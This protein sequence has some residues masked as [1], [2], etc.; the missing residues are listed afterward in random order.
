MTNE[1]KLLSDEQDQI[2]TTFQI[3]SLQRDKQE[4]IADEMLTFSKNLICELRHLSLVRSQIIYP[5]QCSMRK[6][7]KSQTFHGLKFAKLE[8]C[9][10]FFSSNVLNH[11]IFLVLSLRRDPKE[12]ANVLFQYSCKSPEKLSKM[13][14]SLFLALFQQGWCIE[15]DNS[16]Y[17]TLKEMAILQFRNKGDF[18]YEQ[19][20][21]KRMLKFPRSDPS[22]V[23]KDYE[24]FISFV[25][26]YLFNSASLSYFQSSLSPIIIKLHSL[27]QLCDLKT[28]FQA[29][30]EGLA[31]FNYWEQLLDYAIKVCDALYKCLELLPP[32]VFKL[33]KSL[34]E[35]DVDLYLVYFEAF[36]NRALDNPAVLGLLPWHPSHQ[37]W[38]P[39]QDIAN[40]LR[41]KYIESL[42]NSNL[43]NLKKILILCPNYNDLNLEKIIDA[44]TSDKIKG[45]LIS[46][47][48]L[49][50]T[51][52][53]FPKEI[54]VTGSDLCL[55]QQA[56]IS[57]TGITND[58]IL[59]IIDKMS[60]V[61][62]KNEKAKDHFR[63]VI[64][65]QKEMTEAAKNLIVVSIFSKE[66]SENVE[67]SQN[68]AY[69]MQ[70]CDILVRFPSLLSISE[71]LNI[72]TIED[73]FKYLKILSPV[74]IEPKYLL[75]SE[76]VLYYALNNFKDKT[77]LINKI[78]IHAKNQHNWS[79]QSI[80]KTS[81]LRTQHQTIGS[82]LQIA[83]EIRKNVQTHLLLQIAEI[84]ISDELSDTFKKAM[85]KAHEFVED[86][87]VFKES[88]KNMI[89]AAVQKLCE[90]EVNENDIQSICRI[91]FFKLT[92]HITFRRFTLCKTYEN[93][94][95]H[96]VI[97]SKILEQHSKDIIENISKTQPDSFFSK[98]Q[99]LQRASD[100]LGHIRPN[101]G[102]SV[103]V[104]YILEMTKIITTL[105]SNCPELNFDICL[106][107][108]LLNTKAK[109]IF[110]LSK[111]LQH[112][113]SEGG[114]IDCIL[115]TEEITLLALFP[116]S[117]LMLLNECKNYDKRIQ[118]KWA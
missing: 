41:T 90:L 108:V 22:F 15:E 107:W 102:I 73:L 82:S 116:T 18:K 99:Y 45:T 25:S 31:L 1:I 72:N 86:I 60:E 71:A 47:T 117:I 97:I 79:L 114:Y 95:K 66:E 23:L 96:S 20:I 38:K 56:C 105:C 17:L 44:L 26:S 21:K 3:L 37:D 100:L 14:Y 115:S 10:D 19:P 48:E 113:V 64:T 35:L 75:Q 50:H 83:T 101:S 110:L 12:L 9:P 5:K 51:N 80:D 58:S 91:H 54:L 33:F 63:I 85:L 24:P 61:P 94:W 106:I 4:E 39:S 49:L 74:Y 53:C 59:K 6:I 27:S 2:K 52:P 65:R 40:I 87:E 57:S 67:N 88:V 28:T 32:G 46:E 111:F 112:F 34:K 43:S 77:E 118:L 68:D 7:L 36:I 109:H 13:A 92:D 103:I 89:N 29:T 55:L 93:Y 16:I 11:Y 30:V 70:L 76:L 104:H 81:S 98:T 62:K 78:S 69:I 42:P 8:Y 84:M